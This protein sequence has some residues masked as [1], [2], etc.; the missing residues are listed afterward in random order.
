MFPV[1]LFPDMFPAL[2]WQSM[3]VTVPLYTIPP[4]CTNEK[5]RWM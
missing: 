2:V 4:L 1:D 3:A 5:A